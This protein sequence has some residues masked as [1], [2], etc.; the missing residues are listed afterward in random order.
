MLRV[1][2]LFVGLVVALAVG[3]AT[4]VVIEDFDDGD[5]SDWTRVEVAQGPMAVSGAAAHDGPFGVTLG[6]WYFRD[7]APVTVSQGDTISWWFNSGDAAGRS[8]LGFGASAGGTLSFVAAYNTGDIRFQNNAAYDFNEGNTSG[9]AWSQNTWYRAEVVWGAGGA[10]T[11]NLYASDGVTL[12]NS[13]ADNDNTIV[14]GGL[15]LRGFPELTGK[16]ADTIELNPGQGGVVPEPGT[17]ALLGL[18]LAALRRR[19]RI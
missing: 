7:D 17:I 3:P 11:G 9:Q 6:D 5:I 14:S 16:F 1:R 15:A 19:R 10:L 2:S 12:L 4:A 13:V 8:Y 18:G